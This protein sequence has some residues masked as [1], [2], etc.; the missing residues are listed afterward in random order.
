M[1]EKKSGHVGVAWHKGHKKWIAYITVNGKQ[2]YIGTFGKVEDA[3]AARERAETQ[4]PPRKKK[5]EESGN[6]LRLEAQE[7]ER[8]H[9]MSAD[10]SKLSESQRDCLVDYLGGM[11]AQD[12]ADK[13]GIN[14]PVV[15]TRIREAKSIIDTGA[16]RSP[17]EVEKRRKY[18]QK[19]YREHK[20]E[21]KAYSRK[22]A[23]E[24]PEKVKEARQR[25]YIKN[26]ENR[27]EEGR[28]Y[29]REYYQKNRDRILAK[30]KSRREDRVLDGKILKS[31][32]KTGSIRETAQ[33]VGCSWNRVVK[34][35]SSSGIVINDTHSMILR[36]LDAGMSAQDIAHQLSL[37]VK[38]VEAY[39]PRVRPVYGENRSKNAIKINE[40]RIKG[41]GK[42]EMKNE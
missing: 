26:R 22:Y 16:P 1:N 36:L 38:T 40:W 18:A 15:Y 12:I 7:R 39:L 19:Y 8:L 3:I 17:E 6:D 20:D 34:S 27:L 41:K 9:Y 10:M 32:G 31:F 35:L 25:N 23:A 30:A 14:K 28:E 37:N 11:S 2:K 21:M 13:H 24:H 29:N 4:F 42:G 33:E 5:K